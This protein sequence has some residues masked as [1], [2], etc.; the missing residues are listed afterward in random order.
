MQITNKKP[1]AVMV[2]TRFF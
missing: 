2:C 1:K